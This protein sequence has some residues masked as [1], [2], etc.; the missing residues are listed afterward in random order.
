MLDKVPE[1]TIFF[2]IIKVLATTAGE[3]AADYLSTTLHFG[4]IL[5]RPLGA[6]TGDLL[7]QTIKDGDLGLPCRAKTSR[8]GRRSRTVQQF[9]TYFIG[10][11]I[12]MGE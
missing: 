10:G 6:S 12:Q 5:A 4:Y 11:D 3:T 8:L 9:G 2:W 1:I 7:S